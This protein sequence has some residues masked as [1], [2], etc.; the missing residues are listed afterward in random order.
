MMDVE[1][2]FDLCLNWIGLVISTALVAFGVGLVYSQVRFDLGGFLASMHPGTY[3]AIAIGICFYAYWIYAL[4]RLT[5]RGPGKH[6]KMASPASGAR[7]LASWHD[8]DDQSG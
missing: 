4:V 8:R 3:T 6:W 2:S 5:L 1:N 7:T